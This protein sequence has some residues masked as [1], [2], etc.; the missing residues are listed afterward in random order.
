VDGSAVLR[1]GARPGDAL[2]VTGP[3]GDAPARP[4]PRVR[5]GMA[6]RE[7]GAAAMIDISD[8]LALDIRR[9]A[10]ASGVGVVLDAL[11]LAHRAS[12]G[13]GAIVAATAQNAGGVQAIEPLSLAVVRQQI[14][15]VASDIGVHAVKTGML[16]SAELV[17]TV[18]RAL[19]EIGRP[20]LVV[21]P[22]LVSSS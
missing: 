21:D 20:P 9:L 16:A 2:F 18:A 12:W 17:S 4:Q 19:D 22:V 6:A 3:L 1:S 5:E 14:V 11:P 10:S 8:G 13:R 15:S 7:A